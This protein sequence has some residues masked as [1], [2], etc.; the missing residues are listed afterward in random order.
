MSAVFEHPQI[1]GQTSE[2]FIERQDRQ[3]EVITYG[4]YGKYGQ[5]GRHGQQET[6]IGYGQYQRE[7]SIESGTVPI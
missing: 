5:Y 1:H 3:K 7:A 4:K 6:P 2:Q